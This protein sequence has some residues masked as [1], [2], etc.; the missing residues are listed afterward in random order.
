[1]GSLIVL[2][3]IFMGWIL[4]IQIGGVVHGSLP[5]APSLGSGKN[6]F[7]NLLGWIY[8]RKLVRKKLI[9][10]QLKKIVKLKSDSVISGPELSL[11]P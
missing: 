3:K 6:D 2:E 1:M 5:F 4:S 8:T 11:H 7:S 9:R 10:H